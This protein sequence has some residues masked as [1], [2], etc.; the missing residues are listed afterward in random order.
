MGSETEFGVL[1]QGEPGANATVLST[2]VVTGYAAW[3]ARQHRS[4]ATQRN[5]AS[6][7]PGAA[8]DQHGAGAQ[9]APLGTAWD[10]GSEAPLTDARGFT[11]DRGTAHPSQLTDTAPE[12]TA[13]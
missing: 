9:D 6:A 10:Y 13:E 8:A 11:V 5:A 12:H 2:R 7:R 3:V 4:A 1:A